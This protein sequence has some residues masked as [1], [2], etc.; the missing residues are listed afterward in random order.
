MERSLEL[1][2]EICAGLGAAHERGVIHR[3]LKPAN[4]MLDGTG[5]V[6]ITD[7]GLAGVAGE[8]LRAGTPSAGRRV[9]RSSGRVMG[10]LD[11]VLR[12]LL[13]FP[14]LPPAVP[15]LGI[16]SGTRLLLAV[17]SQVV[18]NAGFNSLWIIFAMV[19][20]NL[21]VRRVWITGIVMV[22]FL[23]LT[24]LGSGDSTPP[25]WLGLLLSLIV[26]S[27]I[28]FVMLRFGLLTAITF[29]SVN[30]LLN[31]APLTLDPTRWYFS[32]STTLLLIVSALVLYGFYASR[33]REPLFGRR[34]LD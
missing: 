20:V 33:G 3:D 13:G 10:R 2:R 30:F 4:V 21:L 14:L 19:A 12:P 28:I 11:H 15:H 22:G 8:A 18:F 6:R 7:F 24:G 9:P 25:L 5:R 31:S 29:F 34:L 1:S 16:L 32:T 27:G 17:A 23:M 26:L